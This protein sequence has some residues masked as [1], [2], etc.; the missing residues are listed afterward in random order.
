MNAIFFSLLKYYYLNK[1][2]IINSQRWQNLIELKD[3][4]IFYV[5]LSI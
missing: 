1:I 5:F 3:K 4:K 2:I